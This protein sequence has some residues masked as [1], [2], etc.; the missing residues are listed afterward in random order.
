[1]ETLYEDVI[2]RAAVNVDSPE[3]QDIVSALE[4]LINRCIDFDTF[5]CQVWRYYNREWLETIN[6]KTRLQKCGSASERT[7]LWKSIQ[8]CGNECKL[9]EFDYLAIFENID[10]AIHIAKGDCPDCRTVEVANGNTYLQWDLFQHDYLHT[11]YDRIESFC[12]CTQ[13][14]SELIRIATLCPKC[15]VSRATGCLKIVKPSTIFYRDVKERE[16]CS[17]AFHWFSSAYSLFAPNISDMQLTEQIHRLVVR[18]DIMPAFEIKE[19]Q[20]GINRFVVTKNCPNC[21]EEGWMV[22][23]CMHE[24]KAIRESEKH[25]HCFIMI[26]FLYGQVNYWTEGDKYLKQYHAKIAFLI[27]CE[28]CAPGGQDIN[29]CITDILKTLLNEYGGEAKTLQLP[30][31]HFNKRLKIERKFNSAPLVGMQASISVMLRVFCEMSHYIEVT[32]FKNST[33]HL[34]AECIRRIKRT[35]HMLLGGRLWIAKGSCKYTNSVIYL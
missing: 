8:R 35:V 18:A 25:L 30:G 20:H 1:M 3:V 5:D 9:I 33:G 19:T 27:H 16:D 24:S 31:F 12:D 17:I 14:D 28:T 32:V 21:E 34:A 6:S 10:K 13:D 15:T 7:M 11:V 26:K 29:D 22:S 2:T 4:E 23:H